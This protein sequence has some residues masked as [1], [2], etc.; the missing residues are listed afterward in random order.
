M[1]TKLKREEIDVRDE[2]ARFHH[3]SEQLG[4][5]CRLEQLPSHR[6]NVRLLPTWERPR[7]RFL[8]AS[9]GLSCKVCGSLV[10]SR[11]TT[12]PS[13]IAIPKAIR[14]GCLRLHRNSF[15]SNPTLS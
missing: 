12:S 4:S 15:S 2:T 11:A 1:I 7:R 9:L 10:M 6:P 14:T 13:Y 8:R 3:P 5:R